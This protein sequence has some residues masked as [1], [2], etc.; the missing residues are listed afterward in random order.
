MGISVQ[1]ETGCLGVTAS[2]EE[3]A[4]RPRARGKVER[5]PELRRQAGR[6]YSR[7]PALPPQQ[8]GTCV[9]DSKQE[10]Q[11]NTS[12]LTANVFTCSVSYYAILNAV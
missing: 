8:A 3:G 7:I 4:R 12:I 11:E 10:F 5:M 9:Q 1:N 6:V 2:D